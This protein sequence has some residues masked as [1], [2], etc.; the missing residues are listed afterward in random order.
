MYLTE[1]EV[2]ERMRWTLSKVKRLRL[3]GKLPY[4]PGRPPMIDEADLEAY[5][6]F[7]KRPAEPRE[8]KRAGQVAKVPEPSEEE[9]KIQAIN[10]RALIAWLRRQGRSERNRK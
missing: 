4:V 1:K 7:A 3:T 5:L 2:A 6:A 9:L 8:S 10:R